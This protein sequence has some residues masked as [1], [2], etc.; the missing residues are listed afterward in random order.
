ME[1]PLRVWPVGQDCGSHVTV[2]CFPVE[3]GGTVGARDGAVGGTG[4][5]KKVTVIWVPTGTGPDG[6]ISETLSAFDGSSAGLPAWRF[7]GYPMPARAFR[8]SSLFLPTY[9]LGSTVWAGVGVVVAGGLTVGGG[10]VVVGGTVGVGGGGGVRVG[11]GVVVVGVIV[12]V[13]VGV[14]IRVGVGVDGELCA[15][16][17]NIVMNATTRTTTRM[18]ASVTSG[19]VHGLRFCGS[20]LTSNWV[21]YDGSFIRAVMASAPGCSSIVSS[22][23]LAFAPEIAGTASRAACMLPRRSAVA[24][25]ARCAA[26]CGRS[27]GFFAMHAYTRLRT[28]SDTVTGSSGGVSLI[29]AIAIATC[30]SPVKGRRPAS[31]S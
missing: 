21:G 3:A 1:W 6:L 8:T 19:H 17:L 5:V 2:A 4:A 16:L 29:C 14:T 27:L 22:S 28:G 30:D 10:A 26:V 11:V 23:A 15:R 31:A 7:T 18:T 12:G 13:G 20:G 9:A 24:A 25:R